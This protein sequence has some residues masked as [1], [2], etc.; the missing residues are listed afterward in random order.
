MPLLKLP[1]SAQVAAALAMLAASSS[2]ARTCFDVDLDRGL[3]RLAWQVHRVASPLA[4]T[5]ARDAAEVERIPSNLMAHFAQHRSFSDL[6]SSGRV[7][8]AACR[9]LSL[10]ET[11]D[12]LAD[13]YCEKISTKARLMTKSCSTWKSW[14]QG[15]LA[16]HSVM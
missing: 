3:D 9:V 11:R 8:D 13:S 15:A 14:T 1:V 6:Q 2:R 12:F 4:A 7:S 10:R 5:H 16:R